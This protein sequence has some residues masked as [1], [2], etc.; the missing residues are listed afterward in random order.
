MSG[1]SASS[2]AV[3]LLRVC[4]WYSAVA[5]AC[6]HAADPSTTASGR[7]HTHRVV[8]TTLAVACARSAARANGLRHACR[9]DAILDSVLATQLDHPVAERSRTSVAD[10]P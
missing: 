8:R 5:E 9:I 7:V 6:C 2:S 3:V 4:C 1:A 10:L